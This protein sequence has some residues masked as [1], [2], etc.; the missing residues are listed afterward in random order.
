MSPLADLGLS[1]TDRVAKSRCGKPSVVET[2]PDARVRG[3][4]VSCGKLRY[5]RP[6]ARLGAQE[7][8]I[9]TPQHPPLWYSESSSL[10]PSYRDPLLCEVKSPLGT[11]DR[12]AP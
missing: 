8:L 10:V 4:A 3:V 11:R 9:T 5:L 6:L 2:R 1:A 7:R 12:G